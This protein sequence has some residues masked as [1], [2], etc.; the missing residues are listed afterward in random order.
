MLNPE[1]HLKQYL[2][3]KAY[4]NRYPGTDKEKAIAL[5][6]HA[7]AQGLVDPLP[8]LSGTVFKRWIKSERAPIWAYRASVEL[9]DQIKYLP[10]DP[11]EA[12]AFA[13]IRAL[14]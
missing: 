1:I 13:H 6:Q 7:H 2:A 3:I 12:E 4:K 11:L 9:L 8:E 14:S 5:A 10:G